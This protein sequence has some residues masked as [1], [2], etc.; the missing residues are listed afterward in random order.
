VKINVL[1]ENDRLGAARVCCVR[2]LH[3]YRLPGHNHSANARKKL[4]TA[5]INT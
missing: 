1:V 2:L 3:M 5:N 4:K